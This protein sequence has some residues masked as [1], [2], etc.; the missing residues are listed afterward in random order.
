MT[1][2]WSQAVRNNLQQMATFGGEFRWAEKID[3]QQFTTR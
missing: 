2:D 3:E 1:S